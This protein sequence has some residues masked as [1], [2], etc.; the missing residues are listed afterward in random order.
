MTDFAHEA[1]AEV[2]RN[3]A[4]EAVERAGRSA[5]MRRKVCGYADTSRYSPA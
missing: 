1:P 5:I 2:N 4:L 3:V